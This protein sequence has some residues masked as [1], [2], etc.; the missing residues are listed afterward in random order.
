MF[1][2]QVERVS[3]Y[4]ECTGIVGTA[5]Y[6]SNELPSCSSGVLEQ[7]DRAKELLGVSGINISRIVIIN[8]YEVWVLIV[9]EEL[10]KWVLAVIKPVSVTR[11]YRLVDAL[12]NCTNS[13]GNLCLGKIPVT[14]TLIK[15]IVN[16]CCG[17]CFVSNVE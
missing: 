16:T 12:Q 6:I 4:W 8:C 7:P 17:V 13:I 15:Q 1:S 2:K 3:D 10:A 9:L 14:N 5:G 11:V